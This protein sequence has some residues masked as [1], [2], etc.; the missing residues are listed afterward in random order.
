MN[1]DNQDIYKQLKN[2]KERRSELTDAEFQYELAQI[3]K[4]LK[5]P[6]KDDLEFIDKEKSVLNR[7]LKMINP[8]TKGI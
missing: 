3:K 8:K 7:F 1:R 4:L 5:K 2:L 6:I